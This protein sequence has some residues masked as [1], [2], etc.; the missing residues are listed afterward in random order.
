MILVLKVVPRSRSIPA[1]I[2]L[3]RAN[4]GDSVLCL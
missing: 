3:P 2:V 1:E 4:D